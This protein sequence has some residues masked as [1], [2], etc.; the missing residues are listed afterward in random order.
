MT[1]VMFPCGVKDG[2]RIHHEGTEK[3]TLPE[4]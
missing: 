3:G 2:Q 4:R 1:E